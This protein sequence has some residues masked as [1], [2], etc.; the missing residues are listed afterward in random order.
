MCKPWI[1]CCLILC[2]LSGSLQAASS[3]LLATDSREIPPPL[4]FE[5]SSNDWR[6]LGEKLQIKIGIYS[7]DNPPF[8]QMSEQNVFE[9]ISVEYSQLITHYLGLRM[10]V[11]HYDDRTDAL[12]GLRR[13]DVDIVIDDVGGRREDTTD[14]IT[15]LPFTPSAIALVSREAPLS[16]QAQKENHTSIAVPLG[17]LSDEW[18]AMHYPGAKIVRYDSAQS[19]LSSVAFG[20]N[21]Y[22]IGDVTV[23][24]F[25]IER[26][27]VN[28]LTVADVFTTQDTG[29]RFLLRGDEATLQHAINA[30]LRAIPPAQHEVIF[31]QWSQSQDLGQLQSPLSLTEREQRWLEHHREIHVVIN[32]LYAPFTMF[33]ADGQFHGISADILRLIHLRTG[34]NFKPIS[35]NSV[36]D[37]FTDVKENKADLIAAMS[38]SNARDNQL[39]FTRS[40]V[41]PP[42]VL[43]VRNSKS[44]PESISTAKKLAITPGN[45]LHEWLQKAYPN[46]KL[47]E[48]ANASVA[49]QW[50]NEGKVDGAVHNLI[51]A[52]YMIDRYFTGALKISEQINNKSA[53]ISFAVSRD[54]PELYSIINKALSD[55]P[56]KNITLIAN[57]WHGTPDVKLGT[58]TV[59]RTQFYWLAG[60]FTILVVASLIWNYY[61]RREIRRRQDTQ[62]RLQEQAALSETL[63]NGTPVPVYVVDRQ[64]NITNHNRAWKSFFKPEAGDLAHLPITAPSHP[65][66]AIYPSLKERI[67]LANT[68]VPPLERYNINN[69]HETRMIVHQSVPYFGRDGDVA[70][71]ICSWQDITDHENLLK[72]VF[73]ARERAE[74][75]NRAKSSF[76]ATM[77][78]EIRTPIS[79][80]IGLLELT[81]T[82]KKISSSDMDS[83]RIAY[84]SAQSLMGLIGDILDMAKIESGQLELNAKWTSFN[85]LATPIVRMFN[86]LARQ[87]NI[88]LQSHTD[89]LHP[90]EIFIDPLRFHQILLNLVSNAIKFTPKGFVDIQMKCLYEQQ[91]KILLEIIVTDTGVGI[92]E[93]E[94]EL[95]FLPYKQSEA[96][97]KQIGTG[98]GLT[99]CSS[100]VSMMEGTI[101]LDSLVGRG[102]RVTVRIPVAHR[103]QVHASVETRAKENEQSQP[104]SILA[105]DDHPANRFLLKRQLTRLGHDV[106]EA[107]NGEQ[108]L[109]MWNKNEFDLVITDCS[110][111]VM[112]GLTL[113]RILRQNQTSPTV[114]LGLT[115]NAQQEERERCL[116]AG[117]DDCL[118]KPLRLEQ[119]D[120]LLK[121]IPRGYKKNSQPPIL[122][123]NLLDLSALHEL[124]QHDNELLCILLRTTLEE[125]ERDMQQAR[126]LLAQR[127]YHALAR[128]MH[129]LAGSAQIIGAT[130][131]AKHCR[132]MEGYCQSEHETIDFNINF[133]CALSVLGSLN[134]ALD[135]YIAQI[136]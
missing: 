74:L 113:T 129:R 46:L 117:M 13:G 94:Q 69:G 22:F 40:Y 84:E 107:E 86:G 135:A 80:I 115:A 34:L 82:N 85:E 110:M 79:A 52:N 7:P 127:D 88:L 99:I 118:F 77:S 112:D 83:V 39:L 19:A 51:G 81:V 98:L 87:K 59:Y 130:E 72:A 11:Q 116:E 18:F 43:V 25:L 104:L 67:T 49:L 91:P 24:S 89:I 71:L 131:A 58:W 64:G 70:G 101:T 55:I 76:L 123:E 66:V 92:P 29:Q 48:V 28:L 9:G 65:L 23:S 75:A 121:T 33:D 96:G 2:M 30:V 44:A 15:S 132:A 6:W 32:P 3:H 27:Y 8:Y 16:R 38:Y 5:L 1:F 124:A 97:K 61:L 125:N 109:E 14:L 95:I 45:E 114:I 134:V 17:F 42:F 133:E 4:K 56:P 54:E 12:E 119:L 26:N 60:G 90:D 20:E 108:A 53:K 106:I 21:N 57:K 122:L 100:L 111:P 73:E 78:H 102:T 126:M 128:C 68:S 105:V 31:N 62:S 93:N 50:V 63:F 36:T 10:Q 136:K 37:M 47:V 120:T 103:Q 35:A 41:Q